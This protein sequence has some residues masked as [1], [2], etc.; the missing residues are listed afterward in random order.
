MAT[1]LLEDRCELA[2]AITERLV[3]LRQRIRQYVWAEG[4]ASVLAWLGAAFWIS[5]GVDWFFEPPPAL[6][7]LVLVVVAGVLATIIV[8]RIV[9][10]VFVRFTVGNLA[11]LLERRFSHLD[12]CLLTA[13]VLSHRGRETS[14][15]NPCMLAD[16]RRE[17]ARRMQ[18]VSLGA[19]F[20][21]QPLR[22]SILAAGLLVCS[23]F[24]CGVLLP[25]SFGVWARRT[26]AF[27]NELWPRRVQLEIE[28]FPGGSR[29]VA[30][31]SDVEITVRA[32][33]RHHTIPPAVQI[34]FREEGGVRS[35][36]MMERVGQVDPRNHPYQP[37]SYTRRSVLTPLR[38][39]VLGGDAALRDLAIE[40]VDNPTI[41]DWSLECAFPAYLARPPRILPVS[42]VMSLLQG[43]RVT[44]HARSNK[45][46]VGVQVDT[47][48]EEKA[49]AA[50][51]VI[52][53]KELGPD[54]RSFTFTLPALNQDTSLLFTLSDVDGIKSREPIRLGLV[55]VADQAPQVAARLDGIGTAI[56]PRARLA[57]IGRVSDDYGLDRLWFEYQI[58]QSDPKT[59]VL[60]TFDNRPA[61]FS[62]E[63]L[64]LEVGDFQL[65]PGQKILVSVR[66]ADG[67]NLGKTANVGSSERWLLDVVTP[68]QLRAL[69][70]AREL[71][72]RQ[73]FESILQETTETRDLLARWQP[74]AAGPAPGAAP[75]EEPGE[76]SVDSSPERQLALQ[77]LRVGRMITNCRKTAPETLGL[78][79][80]FDDIRKQLINNR[81]ETEELKERL[82][83]GIAE[84]LRK[85]AKTLFP[86]LERRLER[87]QT[88]LE[89]HSPRTAEDRQQARA[90]ADVILLAM[91]KV[92]DRMLELES[93]HEAVE[94]LREVI[95]LQEQ[96]HRQTELRQKEKLKDLL[97]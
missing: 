31:G 65:R 62:L 47:V 25:A 70:E 85:I 58:G 15:C 75:A 61:E 94:M 90:Q 41:S 67:Y 5:L 44:V 28:D 3:L 24:L 33:A 74:A 78:A 40:V 48:I 91:Q 11:M 72:L 57:I 8:R 36:V 84:P 34:R 51:Q 86:E 30:R 1:A 26:L 12:D 18:S 46:L 19:V 69:L 9:R 32:E 80:S 92:L 23:V 45:E 82:G 37:F 56:T 73:R 68:E 20:N 27:S 35:R 59:S 17:A 96:L 55:A 97:K 53:V 66:A 87:L 60:C 39:D 43:T 52:G 54:R 22:Q 83:R 6:R 71:V 76:E 2:P 64:A 77:L 10:K 89:R 14:G 16:T 63:G 7:I 38:F 79:D 49:A 4:V 88:A 29:K 50:P 95:K 81:L 42:G 13:V 93:Y 21:L